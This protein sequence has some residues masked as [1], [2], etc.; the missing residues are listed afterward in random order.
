[1]TME[2]PKAKKKSAMGTALKGAKNF[3]P[4]NRM[5]KMLTKTVIPKKAGSIV[6][7]RVFLFEG[8][9]DKTDL[10]KTMYPN[11]DMLP[12]ARGETN[13]EATTVPMDDHLMPTN[14]LA[15]RVNPRR[16]PRIEWVPLTGNRRRVANKFQREDPVGEKSNRCH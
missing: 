15:T 11:T 2:I 12:A 4:L 10:Y 8:L 1:M 13:H 7:S 3:G 5:E 6:K 9:M 16:D 14:C